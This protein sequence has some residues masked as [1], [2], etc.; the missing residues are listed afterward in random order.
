[1]ATAQDW[2]QSWNVLVVRPMSVA[3]PYSVSQTTPYDCPSDRSTTVPFRPG[4]IGGI[5]LG[6]ALAVADVSVA[7]VT[8]VVL[9]GGTIAVTEMLV[10]GGG[11]RMVKFTWYVGAD[12][13]ALRFPDEIVAVTTTVVVGG[14]WKIVEFSG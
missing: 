3:P 14:D 7:D 10:V 11:W 1:M 13:E 8:V 6:A 4:Q 12:V 9:P 2:M 5:R